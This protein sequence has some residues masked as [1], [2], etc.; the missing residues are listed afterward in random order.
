MR[1]RRERLRV[2]QAQGD[3]GI[4]PS[5][6]DEGTVELDIGW[7]F[8]YN[9]AEF[10]RTGAFSSQLAGNGPILV[11]C[12]DSSLHTVGSGESWE[13]AVARYRRDGRILPPVLG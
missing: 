4:E 5:L 13:T 9:A 12:R 1:S 10:L 3:S 7:L 11:D 2:Q 8:F 6:H